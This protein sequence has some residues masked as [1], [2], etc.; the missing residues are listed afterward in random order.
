MFRYG[1]AYVLSCFDLRSGDFKWINRVDS[2]TIACPVLEGNEVHVASQSGSYYIFDKETGR[3][4]E[5]LTSV[6]AVSSPTITEQSIFLT[7]RVDGKDRLIEI[8]RSTYEVKKKYEGELNPI[9]ISRADGCQ[10]TMNFNGSHPIVYKNKYVVLAD[11]ERL[12]VFDAESEKVLWEKKVSI[13]TSQ[14]PIVADDRIIL[15]TSQ[16]EVL[17]F[18]ITNGT[19]KQ[20]RMHKEP[21]DAQPVYNKG[22]LFVVSSGILSA[23]RSVH[24]FQWNQWNKDAGHN[25]RID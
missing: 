23:I 9:M 14:V 10:G 22:M 1:G 6:V 15:A 5:V 21:I 18:D 20:I 7:A 2:E 13:A 8:D 12:Q 24:G 19:S 17:S 25:L 3:P 11:H 16:G 4:I